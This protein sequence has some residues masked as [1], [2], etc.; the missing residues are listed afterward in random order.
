MR[1]M[2]EN[3]CV[4]NKSRV[5]RIK[6]HLSNLLNKIDERTGPA[7]TKALHSLFSVIKLNKAVVSVRLDLENYSPRSQNVIVSAYGKH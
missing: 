3:T 5:N 4:Y 1:V 2:I 7:R 6:R